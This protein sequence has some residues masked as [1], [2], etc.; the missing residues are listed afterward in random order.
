MLVDNFPVIVITHATAVD[1]AAVV[2]IMGIVVVVGV[3][4][5]VDTEDI[6]VEIVIIVCRCRE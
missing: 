2:V 4:H 3:M 6:P 5:V 1:A